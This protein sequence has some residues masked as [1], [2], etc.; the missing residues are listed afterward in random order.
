MEKHNNKLERKEPK[1]GKLHIF[2]DINGVLNNR[3]SVL[4]G[5]FF[6]PEKI[7]LVKI[8]L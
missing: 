3:S 7:K 6:L 5:I 2:L 4:E 1:R 8:Y